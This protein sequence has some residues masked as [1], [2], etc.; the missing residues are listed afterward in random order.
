VA[1]WSQTGNIALDGIADLPGPGSVVHHSI[2]KAENALRGRF[3]A[4]YSPGMVPHGKRIA[5]TAL[6]A[7][8]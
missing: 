4:G 5:L 8:S 6:A 1:A 7:L 2:P 3:G